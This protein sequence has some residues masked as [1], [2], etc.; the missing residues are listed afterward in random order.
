MTDDADDA[1]TP[2]Q[3]ENW[4]QALLPMLGPYARI[5]PAEQIKRYRDKMQEWCDLE[6]E[7]KN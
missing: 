6:A 4:R 3:I 7:S 2:E 1:L 5:M